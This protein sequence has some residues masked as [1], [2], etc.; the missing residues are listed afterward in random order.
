M[1]DVLIGLFMVMIQTTV[2]GS[3]YQYSSTLEN[4]LSPKL[5]IKRNCYLVYL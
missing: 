2:C 3:L 5:Q 4:K 1:L